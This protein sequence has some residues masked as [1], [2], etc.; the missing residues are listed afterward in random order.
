MSYYLIQLNLEIESDGDL[1]WQA[2]AN[3]RV[4]IRRMQLFGPRIT[5]SSEGQSLYMSHYLKSHKWTH[6][7]ENIERSDSSQQRKGIFKISSGINRLRHVFVFIINDADIDAQTASL[8]LYITFSLSTD[9]M[10]WSNCHLE[11]GNGNEYPEI[12][13]KPSTDMTCVYRDVL[14]YVHKNN[15]YVK[16]HYSIEVILVPYFLCYILI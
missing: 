13:Y 1:I 7:K 16:G 15:E 11:V 5:F 8:F 4:I 2:G 12:H 6:W 3:C 9:P 10:K 14:K